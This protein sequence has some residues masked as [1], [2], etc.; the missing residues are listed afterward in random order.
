MD[1]SVERHG[2]RKTTAVPL[3]QQSP[4]SQPQMTLEPSR[5]LSDDHVETIHLKSMQVLQAIGMDILNPEARDILQQAG[6]IVSGD[7]A[8]LGRDIIEQ[9]MKTPPSEFTLHAR[10]PARN[11][12]MGGRWITFGPVGGP[13][14]CSDLDRGKRVGN[15][16]D[17][18]NFLRLS[19]FFNCIHISG[20]GCVD[21]TDLAQLQPVD[22]G[23]V[24]ASA[25]QGQCAVESGIGRIYRTADG[26]RGSGGT[27]RFLSPPV[28]RRW[29]ADRL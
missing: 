22:R 1:M 5:I 11:L 8:G 17:N 15:F 7:R 14:N 28:G 18:A 10:D 20:D 3:I 19:Q 24:A 25:S 27:L 6:A 26:R 16:A 12:Q 29:P 13:P 4:W 23:G 9:A 21:A 2:R